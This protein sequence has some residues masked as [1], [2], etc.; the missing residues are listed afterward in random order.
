MIA[1][2]PLSVATAVMLTDGQWIS[3]TPNSLTAVI[4]PSFVDAQTGLLITPGEAWMQFVDDL[5]HVYAAPMRAIFGVKLGAAVT[6]GTVTVTDPGD[7]SSP[8][9]V[10]VAE[11]I[12]A[13]DT[14]VGQVLTYTA[15]GLPAGLSISPATGLISGTPSTAGAYNPTVTARDTAN[16]A[17][18]KTFNWFIT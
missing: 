5:G 18:S 16:S 6:P 11:Q 1:P 9:G 10:P 7:L 8:H 2:V 14:V 13:T 3:L 4:D 15:T 12:I 17:D